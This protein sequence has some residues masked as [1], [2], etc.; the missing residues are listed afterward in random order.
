MLP[1]TLIAILAVT[2]AFAAPLQVGEQQDGSTVVTTRQWLRP[3]GDTVKFQGRPVDLVLSPDGA[4]VFVKDNRGLL[5]IDAAT[6]KLQQELP[7]P[8]D[9]GGSMH[10]IAVSADG[11]TVFLTCAAN[12]MFSAQREASGKWDWTYSVQFIPPKLKE[13]SFPCGIALTRDGKTAYVCLSR[14]N[15]IAVAD[16]TTHQVLRTFDVGVAPYDVLLS[17][18][19][20]ALYV[21]N[22]GGRRAENGERSAPSSGTHVPVDERGVASTGTVSRID[23]DSGALAWTV[24]TGLHPANLALS[25]DALYV[26]NVNSDTVAAIDPAKGAVLGTYP[27]KTEGE[28]FGALPNALALDAVGG[29]LY[30]ACAGLNVL[31]VLDVSKPGAA[32]VLGM[33]PTGWFPGAVA[34]HEGQ[35][36]VANVK[37]LGSRTP[38]P[39]RNGWHV[40]NFTGTVNRIA[41]PDAEQLARH[42]KVARAAARVNESAA[43]REINKRRDRPAPVP[44]RPG[45]PSNIE[46]VVYIIKE[47]RTYDQVF[48]DLPQGNGD[49]SLCIFPRQLTPNMHALAEQFVLLD[50]YYCNGVVSSDGHSWATEGITTDH[51]EKSFGGFSRSYTFGDDP[52]TYA[53]SGFI[54]DGILAAGKTFR[55]FGEFDNT[56]LS[57]RSLKFADVWK[58]YSKDGTIPKVDHD[59]G[60][61]RVRKHSH[62]DAV[63]W[64]MN[65]PDQYRADVFIRDLAEA[66]QKGE[67]PNFTIIYL[68]NDHTSGTDEGMPTPRAH[69]ADN[70]LALGRIVEAVSNSR[71]WPKTAIFV[72]ED[73]PQDGF[74]H[75]DGHR[76]V[77]L[78]ISPFAKR[79]EVVSE[80]YNQT[81][82]LHTIGLIMGVPP[83]NQMD[84]MSTPMWECFRKRADMTPYKALAANSRLDEVN[85]KVAE[86]S[87]GEL[88]LALDSAKMDFTKPDRADEDTLNRILWHA[89]KGLDAAYPAEW[90]GAHGRGLKELGL[91]FSGDYE[92]EEE[93]EHE[94]EEDDDDDGHADGS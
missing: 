44:K 28:P 87:G 56:E 74:D 72:N 63:G 31:A 6:W 17:E 12:R 88:Q 92:E 71:F 77:C 79:G 26:A 62:P 76:S 93:E 84:A 64:N 20:R 30:V 19:E 82:V 66:E 51:L 25:A 91:D 47:N 18:D 34:L 11:T 13:K 4:T 23:L 39:K 61:E 24:D 37:G 9:E 32:P 8:D 80:F 33:I 3:A 83:M 43:A 75:V 54:W 60:V 1:R 7:F 53:S 27:I 41:V 67:W 22:W 65:I 21:S 68:P 57:P 85:K 59:I 73:D 16:L 70:D 46:H 69:V 86:L 2:S 55:N 15:S 10:G 29:K 89:M 38:D 45:Q 36:C 48:G 52:L 35:L 14:N 58:Q 42:T 50:N 81:S 78:V 40:K 49:P 94:E 90:A 5:V